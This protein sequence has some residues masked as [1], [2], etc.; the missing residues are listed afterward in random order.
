MPSYLPIQWP[1][2]DQLNLCKNEFSQLPAVVLQFARLT[3]LNVSHNKLTRLPPA[4]EWRCPSLAKLDLSFNS[5]DS[6]S[7]VLLLP[8]NDDD[9]ADRLVGCCF[10]KGLRLLPLVL[11]LAYQVS[12]PSLDE[13]RL[14]HF[15]VFL[16]CSCRQGMTVSGHLSVC[17]YA[18]LK[19]EMLGTISGVKHVQRKIN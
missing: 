5:L 19:R 7:S 17:A 15:L 8:D 16:F 4:S 11:S 6:Q 14:F 12:S 1:L 10:C 18:T 2:L 9:V 13:M 3:L